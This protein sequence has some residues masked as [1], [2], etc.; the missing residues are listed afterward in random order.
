MEDK[1]CLTENRRALIIAALLCGWMSFYFSKEHYS[2]REKREDMERS[3]KV[4]YSTLIAS[5]GS[6]YTFDTVHDEG[7][8]DVR[9]EEW[10][11]DTVRLKH[12]E[13]RSM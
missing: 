9:A 3:R 6:A 13:K 5:I 11:T 10:R 12:P 8:N 7:V 2:G 1:C 4:F